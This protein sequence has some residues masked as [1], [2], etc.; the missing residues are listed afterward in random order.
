LIIIG[1][2]VN[3]YF[4]V[5]SSNEEFQHSIGFD[6]PPQNNL[7]SILRLQQLQHLIKIQVIEPL[8]E[9]L[10]RQPRPYGY[11]LGNFT[12]FEV[13]REDMAVAGKYHFPCIIYMREHGDPIGEIGRD[14][15]QQREKW[16]RETDTKQD[17]I[18]RENCLDV[19]I[20][21][22]NTVMQNRRKS[23]QID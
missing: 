7:L 8:V 9:L 2:F 6:L 11:F 20:Q 19:C 14:T 16:F 18:C 4:D 13:A 17:R 1:F 23:G 22:N 3:D 15:R 5:L 21:Y 12:A 10:R